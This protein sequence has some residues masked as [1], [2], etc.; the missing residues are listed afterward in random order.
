MSDTVSLIPK[1]QQVRLQRFLP[2]EL[3]SRLEGRLTLRDLREMSEALDSLRHNLSTY[4][5]RELHTPREPAAI[6]YSRWI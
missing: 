1:A 2:A 3:K 5:T 4:L 6:P